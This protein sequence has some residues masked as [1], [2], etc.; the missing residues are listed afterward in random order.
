MARYRLAFVV[1]VP[2]IVGFVASGRLVGQVIDV[3]RGPLPVHVPASYDPETPTPLV[4]L[5][6]GYTSSG[7][8][9]ESRLDIAALVDE[10][11]FLYLYPDGTTRLFGIRFWNA[12]DACCNFSGSNVDDVGYLMDV[13]NE[14]KT[15][16]NV[17]PRRVHFVGHSNGGFMSY[18]MACEHP[19]TIA[20][21]VSMAGATFLD[22]GDCAPSEPVHVLQIHGTADDVIGYN[23]GCFTNCYPGAVATVEQWA[24]YNG[25]SLVGESIPP[26]LD[27]DAGVPGDESLV[28]RYATDCEAGGS[29]E[30]WT[31][32]G[33]GHSPTVSENFSRLVIEFL[34]SHPKPAA[35]VPGDMDCNESAEY[36]DVGPFVTA[37]IDPVAYAGQFDCGE[38]GDLNGD[39]LL[40][41][42]DIGWFVELLA[43]P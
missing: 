20:S 31:V 26:A 22:A 3:G 37:L 36:A 16:Y 10:F 23:G 38:N 6:H 25:C 4:V 24:T 2:L 8:E 21:I 1:F 40:N 13:I 35:Q 17:D 29:A 30:L 32:V 18:R 19:E 39:M 41:G 15:Q 33:G 27:L 14:M 12:T 5:L 11:G 42:A 7:A 9:L 34:F 43:G 28:T